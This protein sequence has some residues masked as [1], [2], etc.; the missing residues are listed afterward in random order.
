MHANTIQ[1]TEGAAPEL[2]HNIQVHSLEQRT[3]SYASLCLDAKDL[4]DPLPDLDD[5]S[6]GSRIESAR[7]VL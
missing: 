7:D 3:K 1:E 5:W 2:S 4:R 6:K